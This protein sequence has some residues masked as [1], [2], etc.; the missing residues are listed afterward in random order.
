MGAPGR[1]WP[2]PCPLVLSPDPLF[3]SNSGSLFGPN[4][5]HGDFAKTGEVLVEVAKIATW[6]VVIGPNR[7]PRFNQ[8]GI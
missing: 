1:T 8:T 7:L 2:T 3:G 5:P 4:V 6:H